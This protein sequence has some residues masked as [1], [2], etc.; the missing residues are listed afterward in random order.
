MYISCCVKCGKCICVPYPK[1]T[2][3]LGSFIM[4]DSRRL[5]VVSADWIFLICGYS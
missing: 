5:F 3:G 4:G 2:C 1:N